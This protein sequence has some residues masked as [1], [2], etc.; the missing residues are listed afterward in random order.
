VGGT[1]NPLVE[2]LVPSDALEGGLILTAG[3]PVLEKGKSSEQKK[4]KET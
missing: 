1:H 4:K 2:F 3:Y